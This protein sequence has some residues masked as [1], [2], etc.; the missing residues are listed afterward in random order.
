MNIK[1]LISNW[2]KSFQANLYQE[3]EEFANLS[4][5]GFSNTSS[6]AL[7]ISNLVR[8]AKDQNFFLMV[9]ANGDLK[10]H[11]QNLE[12]FSA[13]ALHILNLEANPHTD[14]QIQEQNNLELL[15][16]IS[17]LRFSKILFCLPLS[18]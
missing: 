2:P 11:I 5:S 9:N 15:N 4:M 1:S 12:L 8:Q 10:E 3:L 14:K 13:T 6:K 17:I 7:T 16:F 18:K